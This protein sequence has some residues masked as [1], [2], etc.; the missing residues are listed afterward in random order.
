MGYKVQVQNL[1]PYDL[2]VVDAVH[3]DATENA[4]LKMREY[5]NASEQLDRARRTVQACRDNEK[6]AKTQAE[7]VGQIVKIATKQLAK[8]L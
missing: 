7:V 5:R 4:E 3:R 1:F 8:Q 2:L 6:K